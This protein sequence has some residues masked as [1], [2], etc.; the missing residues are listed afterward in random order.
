V[1]VLHVISSGGMYGAEAVILQLS[2]AMDSEQTGSSHIATFA[3]A[4]R[5][6]PALYEAACSADLHAE[7]LPC[8]GQI[9]F[10]VP[11]ALRDLAARV[12]ADVIHAHGYKAD[13]YTYAAFRGRQVRPALVSTCHTWYD[14]DIAVRAYGAADRWVLR[15]FDEV[16]SVSAEVLKRLLDAGVPP[17]RLHIVRNG[18]QVGPDLRGTLTSATEAESLRVG[19]VGRLAPEKGVDVFL[20]AASLVSKKG[21]GVKFA[22]AGEGPDRAALH[23][24]LVELGLQDH[25]E[26][27]GQVRDMEE[28]YSSLDLL[29][30]SSRQEGL[31]M[32]L[33]EGMATGLAVV[34][35][36]VGEVPKVVQDGITGILVPP[37]APEQLACAIESFVGDAEKRSRFGQAGRRRVL[38]EFSAARMTAEYKE[39]YNRALA[40][41]SGRR[42]GGGAL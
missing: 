11:G 13:I 28:F 42:T 36:Q 15:H 8:K 31:P 32:A 4:G 21:S 23:A 6:N 22:V 24:L 18:I 1:K 41:A 40:R 14:N 20:R 25:V 37:D 35:T 2:A 7:L 27:R 38:E 30:S 29:V 17:D 39:I 10:K 5:P 16:V 12:C 19:L 3:H 9:D 26:L 34:A 33:L